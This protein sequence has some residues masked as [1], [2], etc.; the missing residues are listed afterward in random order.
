MGTEVIPPKRTN[1]IG[2]FMIFLGLILLLWGTY[3]LYVLYGP[4]LKSNSIT[5][6][7]LEKDTLYSNTETVAIRGETAPNAFVILQEAG[8]ELK[9][10]PTDE[11]GFFSTTLKLKEGTHKI[12]LYTYKTKIL[13]LKSDVTYLTINIDITR[14]SLKNLKYPTKIQHNTLKLEGNLTEPSKLIIQAGDSRIWEKDLPSGHFN[15]NVPLKNLDSTN[16][17]VYAVDKAGNVSQSQKLKVNIPV[18]VL[19]QRAR[20]ASGI[21]AKK[22]PNSAGI[23][24]LAVASIIKNV[25]T[26][27]FLGLAL[28]GYLG[29]SF[30]TKTFKRE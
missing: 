10:V 5:P 11:T 29:S 2:I 7:L 12:A 13:K 8:K 18:A 28:L 3:K 26:L 27:Y 21:S 25:V 4:T 15:I 30:I 23:L 20:K 17:Y 22:L 19:S 9:K 16:L 6:P 14:P 1:Y 24:D